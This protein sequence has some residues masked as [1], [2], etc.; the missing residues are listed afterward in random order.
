MEVYKKKEEII[1]TEII[2][3]WNGRKVQYD[4]YLIYKFNIY[5]FFK[6]GRQLLMRGASR[7]N[8]VVAQ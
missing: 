8:M 2:V 6:K 1:E 4:V 5:L 3:E 7:R